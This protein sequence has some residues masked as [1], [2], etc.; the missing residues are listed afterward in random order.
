MTEVEHEI[1]SALREPVGRHLYAGA[2]A[3]HRLWLSHQG[4]G[5]DDGYPIEIAHKLEAEG[6]IK[7]QF[8]PKIDCWIAA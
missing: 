8:G 5:P 6:L 3:P 2:G 4:P 7:R 1:V